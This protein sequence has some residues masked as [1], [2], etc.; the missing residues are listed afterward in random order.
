MI[1]RYQRKIMADC[2]SETQKFKHFLAVEIAALKAFAQAG[3]IPKEAVDTIEKNATFRL[4]RIQELEAMTH[5]D[6]IAFTRTISESLGP[7]KRWFHY[8]LTSTD[9]VDT[10]WGL[11]LKKA[12]TIIEEGL[13][14]FLAT[15]KQLALNHKHTITIGRTHGIHAEI[16]S[17]GL[18]FALYFDRFK[19]H[20]ER[21]KKVRHS[22]EVGKLSGAVG[23][24]ALTT[25]QIQDDACSLL[26]L[27][28]APISTQ[29]L[30]RDIH[31]EY[32]SVIALIASGIEQ[33][34]LEIRH[35]MRTEVKEVKEAF[36]AHQK[37]SSAMPHKQN[38]IASENMTGCARLIRGYMHSSFENIGLWHERDISHS[39]VERVILPDALMVL[40][41]MLNRYRNVLDNLVVD[42]DKMIENVA[43]TYGVVHSQKVLHALIDS[44]LTREVA[45]DL[46]QP[47]AIHAYE[48]KK[49][50]KSLLLHHETVL[51]H[52]SPSVIEQCFDPASA[53]KH[54]DSIYERVGLK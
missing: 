20:L 50:F 43:M 32:L 49:Q 15:L 3:M 28:S 41:Y 29:V 9:I 13:E 10:A 11:T 30:P 14:A 44:G 53:L 45:Y 27:R 35:L 39:S 37:G 2:F 12:N 1:E 8:G 17:F 18:K 22:I 5:H 38:P 19:T 40:D 42:T 34:A 51:K 23:N 25:P 7:E 4:E 26:G 33:I 48:Q 31:A 36:K 46:I 52:I 54:M 21:F 47:I 16:T 6:V 24:F